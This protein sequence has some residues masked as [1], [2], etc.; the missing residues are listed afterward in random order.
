MEINLTEEEKKKLKITSISTHE[1][2][3]EIA[4]NTFQ[5]YNYKDG[6][7]SIRMEDG[8]DNVEILFN[9]RQIDIIKKFLINEL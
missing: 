3:F 4:F 2:N 9:E 8:K 7:F 1:L 6:D 5:I